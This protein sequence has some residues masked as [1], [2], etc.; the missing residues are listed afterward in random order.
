M[1][2][3]IVTKEEQMNKRIETLEETVKRTVQAQSL[4]LEALKLLNKK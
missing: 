4:I 2:A 3:Y 1:V